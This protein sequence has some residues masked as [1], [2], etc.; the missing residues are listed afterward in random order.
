MRLITMIEAPL[1]HARHALESVAA[2]KNL[3]VNDW[4]RLLVIDPEKQTVYTYNNGQW[5]TQTLSD[6]N[7]PSLAQEPNAQ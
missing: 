1:E 6:T 4:I 7:E 5:D 3:V 2:V